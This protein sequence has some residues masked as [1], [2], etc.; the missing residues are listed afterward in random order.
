MTYIALTEKAFD[1]PF[2]PDPKEYNKFLNKLYD[3]KIPV[4]VFPSEVYEKQTVQVLSL[5]NKMNDDLGLD[6]TN[7]FENFTEKLIGGKKYKLQRE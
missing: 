4:Y 6:K 2:A 5:L 1:E 7:A 3:S